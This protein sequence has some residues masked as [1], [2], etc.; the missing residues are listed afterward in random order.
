MA[1]LMEKDALIELVAETMALLS[2]KIPLLKYS[3][4]SDIEQLSHLRMRIYSSLPEELD[5]EKIL[6]QCNNIK[7]RYKELSN[8]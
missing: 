6:Q 5:V 1:T 8:A 2:R 4:E 3:E 7:H